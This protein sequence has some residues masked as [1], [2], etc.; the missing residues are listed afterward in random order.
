M[1]INSLFF[2]DC[3][4]RQPRTH[5]HKHAVTNTHSHRHSGQHLSPSVSQICTVLCKHSAEHR[6]TLELLTALTTSSLFTTQVESNSVHSLNRCTSS[7]FIQLFKKAPLRHLDQK[8]SAILITSKHFYQ[9]FILTLIVWFDHAD[10]IIALSML[11]D[12]QQTR[13]VSL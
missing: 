2:H 11:V 9:L 8:C 10:L 1:I 5:T 13:I 4:H 3:K 12:I 6:V 7:G